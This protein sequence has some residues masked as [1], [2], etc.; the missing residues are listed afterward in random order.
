[1]RAWAWFRISSSVLPQDSCKAPGF[2]QRLQEAAHR[3]QRRLLSQAMGAQRKQTLRLRCFVADRIHSGGLFIHTQDVATTATQDRIA[4]AALKTVESRWII[5]PVQQ[6]PTAIPEN[7]RTAFAAV[8]RVRNSE[9]LYCRRNTAFRA[10]PG[11][12]TRGACA[13]PACPSRFREVQVAS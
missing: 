4:Q 5:P 9:N 3:K 6:L 1:M 12:R 2:M 7:S 8:Y 11:W 10:R 13:E